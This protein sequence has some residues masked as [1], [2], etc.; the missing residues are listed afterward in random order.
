MLVVPLSM[1]LDETTPMIEGHCRKSLDDVL[2]SYKPK[3]H[4][5]DIPYAWAG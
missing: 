3:E 5:P 2:A 1:V 4:D